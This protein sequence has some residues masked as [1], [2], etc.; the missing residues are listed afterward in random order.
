ERVFRVL[1]NLLG[2]AIKFTPAGGAIRLSAERRE[3]MVVV[4]LSDEGPGIPP[5]QLGEIFQPYRR[6][7]DVAVPGKGLGL[8]ISRAL[9]E[10]HGGA[11]TV[12]SAPGQG[13][14]FRFTLPAEDDAGAG[15]A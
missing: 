9:V 10:A 15:P 14:T 11:L 4:T 5:D 1:G 3:R 6:G 13:S 2:N 7:A 12:E 8:Y